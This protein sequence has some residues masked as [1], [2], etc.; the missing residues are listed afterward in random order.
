MSDV[1]IVTGGSRGIGAACARAGARAGFKVA[2]NYGRNR[3]AA[4]AVVAEIEKAGGTAFAIGADV[5]KPDEVERLFAET[6]RLLGAV[7]A[8]INNAGIGGA[9]LR[10]DEHR[11]ETLAELFATNTYS[12]MYCAAAA[13]RR[14]ST[15]HGGKGGAI[16]NI[17]SAAARLGG[18]PGMVA[19]AASKGAVDSF[20]TG[21]AK[22]VGREGIR[23]NG[24]RPGLTATEILDPIGGQDLISQVAPTIPI[25]R[26]GR[27]EE[28]AEAA[29]WL[30]SP[31]ASYVHGATIDVT[32]GR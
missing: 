2:V 22:E 9:I 27:P 8:L 21:L 14:M 32:G 15:R 20:T 25:G 13:I 1:L 16:L 17:S 12:Y 30:I 18:M 23:V 7:T 6:D 11:P 19:Y 3:A 29:I 28:I 5:S 31:A 10:I 26:A 24:L 4:D